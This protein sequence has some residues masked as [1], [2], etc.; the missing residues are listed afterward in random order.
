MNQYQ[1]SLPTSGLFQATSAFHWRYFFGEASKFVS[2]LHTQKKKREKPQNCSSPSAARPRSFGCCQREG[3][4]DPPRAPKTRRLTRPTTGGRMSF[5]KVPLA[6]YWWN[7]HFV[8]S[9]KAIKKTNP[10]VGLEVLEMLEGQP[11]F[12]WKF[13]RLSHLGKHPAIWHLFPAVRIAPRW[14]GRS[15][16]MGPPT[17][18]PHLG[19]FQSRKQNFNLSKCLLGVLPAA[20]INSVQWTENGHLS[21]FAS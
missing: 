16:P 7:P 9:T 2:S 15:I 18:V 4:V 1:L 14:H 19:Q 20:I 11:Y 13:K 8:W 5:Q 17:P 3:L 21:P 6:F 12:C 10:Q